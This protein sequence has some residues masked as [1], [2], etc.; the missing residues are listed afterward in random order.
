MENAASA[1]L[2]GDSRVKVNS[3]GINDL[4]SF[5]QTGKIIS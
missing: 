2:L 5:S 4:A 3:S 1:A